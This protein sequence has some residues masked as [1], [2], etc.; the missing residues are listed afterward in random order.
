[1]ARELKEVSCDFRLTP[2]EKDRL[3]EKAAAA[4]M[5]LSAYIRAC[6]A[7]NP[8]QFPEIRRELAELKQ[9]VAHIGNNV[10]QIVKSNH[11]GFYSPADKTDLQKGM[12]AN[13]TSLNNLAEKL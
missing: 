7:G 3:K 9:E 6:L 11:M 5:G 13:A 12:Q 8:S 10:N 2:A 1:M 4:D